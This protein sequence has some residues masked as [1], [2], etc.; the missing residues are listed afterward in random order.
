MLTFCRYIVNASTHF[1]IFAYVPLLNVNISLQDLQ[2]IM[3]DAKHGVI[4]FS[5]GTM[6]QSSKLPQAIKTGLLDI[7]KGLKQTVIW[8]FEEQLPNRPQNVH[9]LRW[10]PQQSILGKIYLR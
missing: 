8:K 9:I 1:T 3:D 6:L 4:Y 5:M 7:F 2:K 10:A